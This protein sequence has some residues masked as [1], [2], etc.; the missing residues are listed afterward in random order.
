[1]ACAPWLT[2]SKPPAMACLRSA[3]GAGSSGTSG[4]VEATA[5]SALS[6]ALWSDWAASAS[7]DFS[8]RKSVTLAID[9]SPS[10]GPFRIERCQPL[11]HSQAP[12]TAPQVGQQGGQTVF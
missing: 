6:L 3:G 4:G 5:A 9:V 1:M 12:V 2:F 7:P 10:S 11:A 8:F